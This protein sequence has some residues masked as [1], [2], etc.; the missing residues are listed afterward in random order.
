MEPFVLTSN[1][2]IFHPNPEKFSDPPDGATQRPGLAPFRHSERSEESLRRM[3]LPIASGDDQR[4]SSCLPSPSWER[5]CRRVAT[6]G[7]GEGP[8]S[9]RADAL[10]GGPHPRLQRVLSR[11]GEG[12]N[13][14]S[15]LNHRVFASS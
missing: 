8:F 9:K 13:Q 12:K 2:R 15:D 11:E 6:R 1:A 7:A 4:A 5:S 10:L 3:H 14:M